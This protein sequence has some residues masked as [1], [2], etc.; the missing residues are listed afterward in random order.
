MSSVIGLE[1]VSLQPFQNKISL[2]CNNNKSEQVKEET[3]TKENPYRFSLFPIEHHDIWQFYKKHE[4]T[5]WTSSEIDFAADKQEWNTLTTDEKH[6]IEMILAFFANSDGIVLEN[7]IVNMMQ[8]IQIPEARSFYTFQAMAENIHAECYGL[9]I[10]TFVQ[11]RIKKKKLFHAIENFP[12][13]R[14][15]SE[16]A[17]KWIEKNNH[18][19]CDL[20][21]R[22]FCFAIVEGLFFS[23]SFC[24][25]FWLKERNK[26]CNSL[27]KSN[28]FIAK[29]EALHTDFAILLYNNYICN[30]LSYSE[31]YMIMKEAVEI[32][33]NFI[34]DSIRCDMIGMSREKMAQYI[35]SCAD[36]LMESFQFP[37]IYN[38]PSPFPFMQKLSMEG[39]TNFFEARLSEYSLCQQDSSLESFSNLDDL[40][41]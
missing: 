32:E 12:C 24:A 33:K 5:F 21:R 25:I 16:W 11:D 18:D 13:V 30:K 1:Q 2:E 3:L 41:F 7:L 6:F 20:G 36:R 22:L 29:D 26:L 38:S 27:G 31:A 40:N 19:A 14:D 34:C 28:E 23:G 10:E 35:E 15:K 17:I 9:M 8:D 39:K 37:V 4:N